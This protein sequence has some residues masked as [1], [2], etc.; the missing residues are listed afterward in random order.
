M[1][2]RPPRSTRTDTLFPYTTLFRFELTQIVGENDAT[3]VGASRVGNRIILSY[4]GDAKSEA[5]MVAL[6]GKPIAN[7]HLDDIGSASGFGGK[8]SDPETFYAF[9]SY[10]RPTTI[11]RFDTQTG[12]SEIFAQPKLTFKP[13][14]FQHGREHV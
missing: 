6:D 9:S 5:R 2:L 12:K 4:L 1:I 11:Y 8:S 7:I 10:A 14:H 13:A 3:L